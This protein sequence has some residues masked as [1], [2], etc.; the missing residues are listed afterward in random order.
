M[1]D[2]NGTPI[3]FGDKPSDGHWRCKTSDISGG[4]F[5]TC[6]ET[7]NPV[8]ANGKKDPTGGTVITAGMKKSG[9]RRRNRNKRLRMAILCK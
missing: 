9:E 6:P 5:N 4:L 3:E 8:I 2:S 7:Q 1:F